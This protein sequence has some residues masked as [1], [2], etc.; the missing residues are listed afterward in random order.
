MIYR[1]IVSTIRKILPGFDDFVLIPEELNSQSLFLNW[2]QTWSDYLLRPYQI[3]DGSLR[4]M[5]LITLLMQPKERLPKIVV[6]DEPELGLHPHA[7][8]IIA[9]LI[10]SASLTTQIIVATQSPALLDY[11][12]AAEVIVV[13][14]L[15]GESR[16]SRLS[17]D[18]LKDWL[19]RYSIGELWEKNVVGGGPLR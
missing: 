2:K 3:S 18:D 6:L 4:A 8:E 11:F 1:R 17:A 13:D 14:C 9:G 16:F 19:N 5:A 12:E 10:R 7:I 15:D